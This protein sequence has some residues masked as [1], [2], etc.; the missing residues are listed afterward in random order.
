MPFLATLAHL[1][2]QFPN[3]FKRPWTTKNSPDNTAEIEAVE[4][5]AGRYLTYIRMVVRRREGIELQPYAWPDGSFSLPHS[6]ERKEIQ[7]NAP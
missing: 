7:R 5:D 1:A 6:Y 3:H 4:R 2:V